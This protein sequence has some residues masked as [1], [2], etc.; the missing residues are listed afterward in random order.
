MF[1]KVE[2]CLYDIKN[3]MLTS[4]QHIDCYLAGKMKGF[5]KNLVSLTDSG[6]EHSAKK[7]GIQ[8]GIIR[9]ET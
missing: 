2:Y 1:L 6:A 7:K 4:D 9:E 8:M 5:N 3:R